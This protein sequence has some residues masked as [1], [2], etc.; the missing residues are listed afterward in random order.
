MPLVRAGIC[1]SNPIAHEDSCELR[2][3]EIVMSEE[4]TKILAKHKVK[5]VELR[6]D[7][8]AGYVQIGQAI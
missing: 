2:S 4:L 1:T 5:F 7:P 3:R 6:L 8:D